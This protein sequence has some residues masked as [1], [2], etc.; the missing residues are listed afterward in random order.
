MAKKKF[1]R[2]DWYKYSKLGKRRKKKQKYRKSKGIDNKIRLKLKS[3]RRNI[4]IGYRS[5]KEKRGLIEG[6]KPV[7]VSNLKELSKIKE[8][9]MKAIYLLD[10]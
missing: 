5:E 4:E 1:L 3:R 2:T 8:G 7:N 6:L 10:L 9:E